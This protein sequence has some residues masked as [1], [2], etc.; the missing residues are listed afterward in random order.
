VILNGIKKSKILLFGPL[1]PPYNGQAIAFTYIVQALDHS[2]Y[3]LLNTAK[4][5]NRYLDFLRIYL[6]IPLLFL[7]KKF[8]RIYFTSSRTTF[9]FLRDAP[10]LL[11]GILF[12]KKIIN[13]LHGADFKKFYY[14]LSLLKPFVR[15]C[16]QKIDTSIVLLDAMK[17]EYRVFPKMKLNVVPNCFGKEFE[18]YKPKFPKP[19]QIVFLSNIMMSK[20]ILD[21][22]ES[23]NDLLKEYPNLKIKIAG[24]FLS[25]SFCSK[26]EIQSLFL[27]KY[28][29]IKKQFPNKIEYIGI[30]KGA[31]KINLLLESSIFVLP[32]YYPTEA[33]PISIL[34]AMV[35]GNVIIA[36][37]H[38]HIP[39]IIN[40]ENGMLVEKKSPDD[41]KAAI[42]K[43]LDDE[44]LLARKQL[45][46]HE[47]ALNNYNYSKYLKRMRSIIIP[48]SHDSNS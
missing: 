40:E 36:T 19:L 42:K 20:G 7:T 39:H 9:G 26:K 30:V 3:V 1:P 15:Y 6:L 11:M 35:A 28:D 43:H 23:V 10:L 29:P 5:N 44:H 34:E 2:E 14:S 46:N 41:Q 48:K 33:F 21:F 22:L 12:K 8:D 38:N 32:T 45:F 16:Y 47:Y 37:K 24:A 13:H 27:K 18:S 17:S 31:E 25:D 4:A